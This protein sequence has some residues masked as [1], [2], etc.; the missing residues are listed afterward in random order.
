MSLTA[1]SLG[2]FER[3]D[4]RDAWS[5]EP[6]DFTPWLAEAENLSL[7]GKTIKIDLELE[8]QEKDIGLFR[9]DILC[10]NIETEDWILIENQLERT[11]HTH[12][13]QLI[14][15]AAGLKAVTIVWI[16]ACFTEEHRAAIDWLN[17]ITDSNFNFFALEIE[18]WRIGDSPVAPKFNI[19]CQPNDWSKVVAQNTSRRDS[20]TETRQLQLDFWRAFND[21]LPT[22]KTYFTPRKP[23]AQHWMTWGIG[24]KGARLS[25]IASKW[26]SEKESYDSNELRVELVLDGE[27]PQEVFADLERSKP[28][29]ERE[30]TSELVWHNPE[31]A[32]RCTIYVRKSVDLQEQE[33]WPQ[34]HKW[35]FENLERFLAV[36]AAPLG[37]ITERSV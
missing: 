7:L 27:A 30:L 8:G 21:F 16:A 19:I 36:F 29:L 9:A 4:L 2:R 20:L 10:K 34:Y 1:K 17:E 31:N 37:Q 14:T 24:V 32:R 13:G 12:L 11:D 15:Y 33:A 35:L 5:S 6:G 22:R 23:R 26:D 18:L 25:A 3:V 28:E